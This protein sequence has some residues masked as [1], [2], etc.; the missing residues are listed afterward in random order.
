MSCS[1]LFRQSFQMR[2]LNNFHACGAKKAPI[3]CGNRSGM[4]HV[5]KIKKDT[6]KSVPSGVIAKYGEL[7]FESISIQEASANKCF[8]LIWLL[9]TS[10]NATGCFIYRPQ[11]SCHR[12]T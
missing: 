6:N 8:A 7:V 5:L 3:N 1:G 11:Q 4:V 2:V 12:G 10:V 9:Q